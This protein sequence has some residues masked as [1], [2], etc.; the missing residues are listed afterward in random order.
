MRKRK[1]KRR[2]YNNTEWTAVKFRFKK[3]VLKLNFYQAVVCRDLYSSQQ[4]NIYIC[5]QRVDFPE[6][7]FSRHLRDISRCSQR[8]VPLSPLWFLPTLVCSYSCRRP[9]LCVP[10]TIF[11]GMHGCRM[12]RESSRLG[13]VSV[14]GQSESIGDSLCFLR[15][16]TRSTS[17]GLFEYRVPGYI[18]FSSLIL[19]SLPFIFCSLLLFPSL[20]SLPLPSPTTLFSLPYLARLHAK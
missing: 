16:S 4:E 13:L 3:A 7:L 15:F 18:L 14:D 10:Y 8:V 1:K 19:S 5:V 9:H 2:K 17:N 6:T 12:H 11:F 20:P